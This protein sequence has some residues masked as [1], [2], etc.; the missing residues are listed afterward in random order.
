M[1]KT[2]KGW[3]LQNMTVQVWDA[4]VPRTADHLQ[5]QVVLADL[6]CSG[7]GVIGKKADIKYHMSLE[8]MEELAALQ[9]E[10]LSVAQNYVAPGGVLIYSTCTVNP[11]ENMDNARWFEANFDFE[12]TNFRQFLPGI[13]G[14]DGFFIAKFVRS[15]KNI[16]E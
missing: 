8:Q 2:A 12:M 6:P 5:A 11:A 3:A 7:L 1:R 14:C 15:T 10:I 4:R 16:K 13:D 9:R